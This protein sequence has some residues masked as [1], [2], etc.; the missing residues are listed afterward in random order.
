MEPGASVHDRLT[1]TGLPESTTRPLIA[2]DWPLA[3]NVSAG[4][5]SRRMRAVPSK[6]VPRFIMPMPWSLDHRLSPASTPVM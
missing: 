3:V 4:T 6:A 5:W 1:R 2:R